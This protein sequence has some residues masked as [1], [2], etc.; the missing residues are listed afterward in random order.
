MSVELLLAAVLIST[1]TLQG[2]A[3]VWVADLP[4]PWL[5]RASL[6]AVVLSPL[7]LADIAEPFAILLLEAATVFAGL[8]L[9]GIW[10]TREGTG[11]S[12]VPQQSL[13]STW[14]TGARVSLTSLLLATGIAAVLFA[15]AAATPELNAK[16]WTSMV[17][18]GCCAG[19]CTLIARGAVRSRAHCLLV[20]SAALAGSVLLAV[21]LAFFDWFVPSLVG[22]AGWPPESIPSVGFLGIG[23]EERPIG[24]WFF[25]CPGIT[26]LGLGSLYAWDLPRKD[27]AAQQT[28]LRRRD[29]AEVGAWR[30]F[31]PFLRLVLVPVFLIP[32]WT[33]WVLLRAP[34]PL[35][36]EPQPLNGHETVTKIC[37]AIS[38]SRF[39]KIGHDWDTVPEKELT[40]IMPELRENLD[41][42]HRTLQLPSQVPINFAPSDLQT[43]HLMNVRATARALCA[44]GKL[45]IANGKPSRAVTS[46]LDAASL[47]SAVR[48][49][50]LL[51][52]GVVGVACTSLGS[53]Q[54]F[55]YREDLPQDVC[56]D[57]ASRLLAISGRMEPYEKLR[58]RDVAWIQETA[59]WHGRLQQLLFGATGGG[60][61]YSQDELRERFLLEQAVLRLVALEL[62]VRAYHL[63]HQDWPK[64]LS[65]LT[66]G[67]VPI[68]PA[69]PFDPAGRPMR[70]ELSEAGFT[71]YSVGPNEADDGGESAP[72]NQGM[73]GG[74][75]KLGDVLLSARFSNG[76]G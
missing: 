74:A 19:L 21:P 41:A 63:E 4:W 11:H 43:D 28:D 37:A 3:S 9:W 6:M 24:L 46:F 18:I 39:E 22:W 54:L 5:V 64:S 34:Q 17:L 52:H 35:L 76:S 47:G 55:K 33:L 32:A 1:L 75:S 45:A 13:P 36:Q 51:V 44:D 67:Y 12:R 2:V 57:A 58:L 49:D 42:L 8:Y 15:V 38:T 7:L 66:P 71:L 56:T 62:A 73:L 30:L 72:R 25:I 69:D 59:G 23:N 60:L 10:K 53:K 26:L 16:A 29:D 68:V 65:E 31:R 48:S 14:S 50:G 27:A 20:V 40:A 61:L 70:Y